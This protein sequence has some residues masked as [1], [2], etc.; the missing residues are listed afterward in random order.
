VKSIATMFEFC[1]SQIG[2]DTRGSTLHHHIIRMIYTTFALPPTN[3]T[4]DALHI[5]HH[6]FNM[7]MIIIYIGISQ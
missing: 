5:F 7:M 2:F 6:V 3:R 1:Q 4:T